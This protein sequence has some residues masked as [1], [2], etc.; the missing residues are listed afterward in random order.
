[1]RRAMRP[2]LLILVLV[3][4]LPLMA[5]QGWAVETM[6]AKQARDAA[7]AGEIV[8]ID[9]RSEDEWRATGIGDVATPITMH[10]AQFI[11]RLQ[12]VIDQNPDKKIAFICAVGGR[13]GHV[14]R[15]LASQGLTTVIDVADG[16][17]GSSKGPGWLKQA[18]P[19]KPAPPKTN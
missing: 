19:V 16:M 10:N 13:S 12:A 18:L 11:P 15:A 9:V 4:A 5:A 17:L 8:L 1:M 14:A 6:T 7:L 3:I 2:L